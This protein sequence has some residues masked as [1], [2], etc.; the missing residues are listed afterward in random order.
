MSQFGI[1]LKRKAFLKLLID[2]DLNISSC[3]KKSNVTRGAISN[4]IKKQA[5][6][7][8]G[9]ANKLIR[10]LGCKFDTI[11]LLNMDEK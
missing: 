4:Y 1:I 9:V 5:P 3:A 8:P 2:K 7:S 6:V 11:F 10:G